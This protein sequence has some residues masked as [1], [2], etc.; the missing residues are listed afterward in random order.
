MMQLH[1]F[2]YCACTN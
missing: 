2:K 1:N